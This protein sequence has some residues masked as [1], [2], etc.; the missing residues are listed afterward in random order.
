MI[1]FSNK[2][3]DKLVSMTFDDLMIFF[4]IIYNMQ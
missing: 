2:H 4:N 3:D 1:N